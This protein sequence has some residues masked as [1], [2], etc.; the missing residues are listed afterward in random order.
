MGILRILEINI[1]KAAALTVMQKCISMKKKRNK[2]NDDRNIHCFSIRHNKQIKGK[3]FA[4]LL[5]MEPI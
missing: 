5:L 2:K 1:S 3:V 4:E